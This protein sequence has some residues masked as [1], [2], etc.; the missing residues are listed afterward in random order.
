MLVGQP[1]ETIYLTRP[2][3]GSANFLVRFQTTPY[4]TVSVIGRC[5]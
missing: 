4:D 3:S 5:S 1:F 2:K